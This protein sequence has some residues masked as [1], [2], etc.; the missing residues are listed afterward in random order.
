MGVRNGCGELIMDQETGFGNRSAKGEPDT[1]RAAVK[2]KFFALSAGGGVN[3]ECGGRRFTGGVVAIAGS[4]GRKIVGSSG[5]DS[6][7]APG[8]GALGV[9][10]GEEKVTA[11][12]ERWDRGV[13]IPPLKLALPR[14]STKE[15]RAV[16]PVRG[17]HVMA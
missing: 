12:I 11:G 8:D 1:R 16:D 9:L 14:C 3:R 6:D 7:R 15:G 5:L 10:F 13:G 17:S 4:V 2:K